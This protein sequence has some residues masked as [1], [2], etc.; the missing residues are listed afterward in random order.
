M[1][2]QCQ[3]SCILN[4]GT[5]DD[6]RIAPIAAAS[7]AAALRAQYRYR[8]IGPFNSDLDSDLDP[9]M[10]ILESFKSPNIKKRLTWHIDAK[11]TPHIYSVLYTLHET[12]D[13][14]LIEGQ[15]L[16]EGQKCHEAR[17]YAFAG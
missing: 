13:P 7:T 2:V 6:A 9:A 12:F 11:L 5:G 3:A 15:K 17:S 4:V 8:C 14:P 16:M 1:I 10:L